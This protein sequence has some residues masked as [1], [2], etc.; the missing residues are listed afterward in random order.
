MVRE[1]L[2]VMEVVTTKFGKKKHFQI[3]KPLGVF[4]LF[5]FLGCLIATGLLAHNLTS[6]PGGVAQTEKLSGALTENGASQTTQNVLVD[7]IPTTT[8]NSP[9]TTEAEAKADTNVR[10]PRSVVPH[11]YKLR[12]IPFLQE[13]NFTFHGEV[14]I[15]VNVTIPTNNITLHADDLFIHSVSVTDVGGNT[16]SIRDVR[17]V[18]QKQFLV[19]DLDEEVAAG[20]QYYVYITFKGVLNDLL[21]GFYRSSYQENNQ[22]R[23]MAATQFQSTDARRC[24]PCFDEPGLKARFQISLARPKDMTSISNMRKINSIPAPPNL[25]DYEWDNYEESLPMSTYLIAFVVSDFQ[26]I[27]NGKISIW[28]RRSALNQAHYGLEIAPTILEYYEKFFGIEYPLPKLDMVAI[29]DFS[30]GAMENWG[31]ITYREPVLLYEKGVSSRSSLQRIAH[32]VA[33]ELAHQWFGNLVTPTWWTDLWLN[34]GFATYVEFLG[35]YAVEPKWKDPDLFL[36]NELHGAF[37]LDALSTSHPISIKVNNPDEINDIFDRISYSKGASIIRMMQHFLSAEVFHKGLNNYLNNSKYSNAEQDDLWQA[38][39]VVS[40]QSKVL[41]PDV[42]VKEIMDTWTLQTGYPV[43][44]AVSIPE[45]DSLTL[46]QERFFLDKEKKADDSSWWIPLTYTDSRHNFRTTWMRKEPEITLSN[47]VL[48]EGDWF[49]LNVNQTGYYRVNYDTRNWHRI[50]NQLRKDFEVFDL[51]NRAQ[52]LDD[53]LNL[54]FSGYISYDIALNVTLYLTKEREFVPWNTG[55]DNLDY[56]YDMF[57]RTAH[58]DKYKAY[59]LHLIQDFY[60]E[61]GFKEWAEDEPLTVLSRMDIVGKACLLGLRDCIIK[62]VQ[63]FQNWKNTAN[64]DRDNDISPDL[65]EIVY[66]TAISDG[67]QEEWDFAWQRY[68]TTNVAN[69]KEILLTALGCSKETWILSRYLEWAVT[70]HA[71]IRKHDSARVFASVSENPVGQDLAYRFL[72]TN[73]NRIRTYLGPSSMSLVSIVRTSTAH[74]NTEEEVNDFKSFFSRKYD[75]FGVA[76]R[77]AQ[78]SIEQGQANVKWMKTY[79]TTIVNWLENVRR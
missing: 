73:W 28:A 39:T 48:G 45:G 17:G 52:F 64:P 41:D 70:E 54:A 56:L 20:N 53:A 49:L 40:H 55:L 51:K 26:C 4:L 2:V 32:V 10:L 67:G 43:V 47:V 76:L 21:Q 6:C 50:I 58:F 59:V 16:V 19:I 62:A 61:L 12:L 34:E 69:E 13:G 46:T 22:T 75:E 74:F 1:N 14:R 24:F 68:L 66:C 27:T 38:F 8:T 35:A 72:K 42:S 60:E 9:T 44:T 78:Q 65:R 25:P 63:L 79:F 29:P 36:V 3:S 11:S 5:L 31:L 77:T 30:G 37:G 23:W 33:H 71:G 57:V 15:L 18:K 7:E